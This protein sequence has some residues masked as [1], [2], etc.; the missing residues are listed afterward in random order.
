MA[1]EHKQINFSHIDELEDTRP[2]SSS[3]EIFDSEMDIFGSISREI[4]ATGAGKWDWFGESFDVLF[5]ETSTWFTNIDFDSISS[6]ILLE[7]S[8][9]FDSDESM[10]REERDIDEDSPGFN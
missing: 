6:E 5:D 10:G 2:E 3:L 1:E 4:F 8:K 7:S 9:T